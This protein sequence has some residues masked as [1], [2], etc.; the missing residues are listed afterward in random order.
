MKLQTN[1][2][3][4]EENELLEIAR[5]KV[6]KL[7]GFYTH[8]FIYAIGVIVFVLKEYY[9]VSFNFFPVN[10]INLLV[11][12]IW[13]T[14]FFISAFDIL[15]RYKFFGRDWEDAKIKRIM[16]KENNKQTWE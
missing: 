16:E 7:K 6:K 14:A 4:E 12:Q 11:M 5:K 9:G 2:Y 15:V 8:A 10:Q 3:Q 1:R 13:S